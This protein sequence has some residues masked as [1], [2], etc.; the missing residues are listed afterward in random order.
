VQPLAVAADRNPVLVEGVSRAV[1][2]PPRLARGAEYEVALLFGEV[3]AAADDAGGEDKRK[4]SKRYLRPK[5]TGK[6]CWRSPISV[7]TTIHADNST[8]AIAATTS[9]AGFL[10]IFQ[11]IVCQ[12]LL[13]VLGTFCSRWP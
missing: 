12:S 1:E 2:A 5:G 6:T 7:W 8:T 10:T 9:I 4:P 11:N 3:R 13:R